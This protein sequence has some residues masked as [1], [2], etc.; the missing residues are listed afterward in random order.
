MGW[1]MKKSPL[2][3]YF[4][5]QYALIKDDTVCSLFDRIEKF[6]EL[7]LKITLL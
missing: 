4:W 7:N 5:R 2:K 3:A 1:S 6:Y